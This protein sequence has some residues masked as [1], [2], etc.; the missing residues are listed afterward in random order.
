MDVL[1][2]MRSVD[3]RGGGMLDGGSDGGGAMCGGNETAGKAGEK[4]VRRIAFT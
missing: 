3:G 1:D 2:C 4:R